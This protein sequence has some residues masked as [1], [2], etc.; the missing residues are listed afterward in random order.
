MIVSPCSSQWCHLVC[1][2]LLKLDSASDQEMESSDGKALGIIR[3]RKPPHI[4]MK[5]KGLLSIKL[6]NTL[7]F[8]VYLSKYINVIT[9]INMLLN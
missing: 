4:G 5:D 1:L 6:I 8:F 2:L 3:G 9:S 7:F